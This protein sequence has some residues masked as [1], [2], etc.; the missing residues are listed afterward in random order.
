[1]GGRAAPLHTGINRTP[2]PPTPGTKPQFKNGQKNRFI[3]RVLC[4]L[5]QFGSVLLIYFDSATYSHH[6]KML[7]LM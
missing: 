4:F 5:V 3:S 7:N 1:M 2:P 6:T